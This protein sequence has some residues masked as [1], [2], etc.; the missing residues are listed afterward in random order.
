MLKY[1]LES[2]HMNDQR[3]FNI[4]FDEKFPKLKD[5]VFLFKNENKIL[6]YKGQTVNGIPSG[7]SK[8]Y[9]FSWKS[10]KINVTNSKCEFEFLERK[11][12]SKGFILENG[13]EYYLTFK[14][15]KDIKK[16]KT[17]NKLKIFLVG[18]QGSG[19]SLLKS[20]ILSSNVNSV[21]NTKKCLKISQG[22]FLSNNS[23]FTLYDFNGSSDFLHLQYYFYTEK[24]VYYIVFDCSKD[25]S[26]I[27]NTIHFWIH[28]IHCQIQDCLIVLIGTKYD[29]LREQ[30]QNLKIFF[31]ESNISKRLLEINESNFFFLN[32]SNFFYFF[33]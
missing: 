20:K 13:T 4:F 3:H 31:N 23:E 5:N 1:F 21:K 30:F 8:I 10:N 11:K 17:L 6:F 22:V 18:D 16:K 7:D 19:K 24:S 15:P 32:F 26:H 9:I 2:E 12:V 14:S 27:Y 29:L 25:I 28:R 33:S